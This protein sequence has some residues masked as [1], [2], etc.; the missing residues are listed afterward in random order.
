MRNLAYLA[1]PYSTGIEDGMFYRE[2]FALRQRRRSLADAAAAQL[3]K[4]EPAVYSPITH[5]AALEDHMDPT[6]AED[7][8]RWM[9]SCEA[10]LENSHTLYVLKLVG[11]EKSKGV[12]YEINYAKRNNLNIIFVEF[13]ENFELVINE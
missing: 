12:A 2:R 10:F 4:I 5:G 9:R 6:E 13:N 3:F 8:S 7:W 11:W 1:C